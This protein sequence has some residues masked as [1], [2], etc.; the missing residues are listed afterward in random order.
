MTIKRVLVTGGLG[1]I[2][3]AFIRYL[4]SIQPFLE[5]VNVDSLTYAA[6]DEHRLFFEGFSNYKE[7]NFSIENS[8][9]MLR[10]IN[11]AKPD[12][13]VNFAA[14]S[15][16]DR[17]IVSP[18]SFFRTNVLGTV[19]LL[20]CIKLYAEKSAAQPLFIHV[21]TDEVFGDIKST[22]RPVTESHNYAPSSPYAASKA[23]SDFVVRSWGRTF[24][25]PYL[26]THC[27]NNFGPFQNSEKF[28]P[29]VIDRIL[30]GARIPIYGDGQQIRDWIFVDDH[31]RILW[32][33]INIGSAG[34]SYNVSAMNE[35]K[36]IDVAKMIHQILLTR[37]LTTVS[38]DGVVEHVPDRKGHDVRY[39]LDNSK[40][41][42]CIGEYEWTAFDDGLERSVAHYIEANQSR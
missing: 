19:N 21:S 20:E 8:E 22:E 6:N 14:E 2:G 5:I 37:G 15:H 4:L 42:D 24:N 29:L 39:A 13:I 12:V 31:V 17:S 18:E 3:G 23:S 36:N 40:L 16:V 27:S 38:F 32:I 7:F 10:V 30:N 11:L 33:L 28:I 26:I 41:I 9:D 1:F 25:L 34:E 35:M